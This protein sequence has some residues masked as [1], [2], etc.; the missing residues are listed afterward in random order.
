M[1]EILFKAKR[2]DN[3][4]W[5]EGYYAERNGKPFIGIDISIYGD[6]FEVFCTPVIRWFEVD[7]KTL[8]QFTGLCDKNGEKIWE[9]D[10]LMC[11]GNPQELVRAVFGEFGVTD[12][13][14]ENVTDE[15]VGWHYEVIYTDELSRTEPFCYSMPLTKE[16]IKRLEMEVVENPE[17]LQ[18]ES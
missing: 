18:E 12:F 13:E 15:V 16:Y 11:H 9:N 3:G 5:V 7:P 8:C 10:I 2:I 4:K 1:R 17:L 14:T 6:I